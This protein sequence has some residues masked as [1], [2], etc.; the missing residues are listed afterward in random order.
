[1]CVNR[2][3]PC[4]CTLKRSHSPP[5]PNGSASTSTFL[6]ELGK[7]M[8]AQCKAGAWQLHA[9]RILRPCS[10]AF[11]A[12]VAQE[13]DMHAA[14]QPVVSQLPMLAPPAVPS[15][16]HNS[17]QPPLAAACCLVVIPILHQVWGTII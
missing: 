17:A 7:H 6:Q 3:S 16:L 1:M 10:E 12:N 5:A 11:N 2:H 4:H 14:P 15:I 8:K 9:L 13:Q